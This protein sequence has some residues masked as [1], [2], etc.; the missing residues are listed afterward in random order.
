MARGPGRDGQAVLLSAED[1]YTVIFG[2]HRNTSLRIEKNGLAC[3][4]V[5]VLVIGYE[6]CHEDPLE[7]A[8]HV[9][10]CDG[11]IPTI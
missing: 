9:P 2:S 6:C 3:S 4:T 7:V 1:N 10:C 5:S 8:L 11:T